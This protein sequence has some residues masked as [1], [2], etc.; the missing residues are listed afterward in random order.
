MCKLHAEL[1]TEGNI[2]S[3]Q[4]EPDDGDDGGGQELPDTPQASWHYNT[5]YVDSC[6]DNDDDDYDDDDDDD[7][8]CNDEEGI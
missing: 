7:D 3:V 5:I 8:Y 2:F 1:A 6:D 4:K